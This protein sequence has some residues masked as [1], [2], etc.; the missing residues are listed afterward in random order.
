M[1]AL[2]VE[3]HLE[4]PSTSDRYACDRPA[5]LRSIQHLAGLADIAFRQLAVPKQSR[6]PI[7]TND[8]L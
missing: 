7:I 4:E 6:A 5:K 3:S 2:S 8:R 1:I